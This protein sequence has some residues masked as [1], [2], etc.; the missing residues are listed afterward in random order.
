MSSKKIVSPRWKCQNYVTLKQELRRKNS[1]SVS[2]RQITD[3][4]AKE[5]EE[6]LEELVKNN[7][8]EEARI[9]EQ[10]CQSALAAESL[11][12]V[13]AIDRAVFIMETIQKMM[14]REQKIPIVCLTDNKSLFEELQKTKDPEEKRFVCALAPIRVLEMIL[15]V[16]EIFVR[17]I[18]SKEMTADILTKKGVNPRVLRYHLDSDE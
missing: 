13:K 9:S 3:P 5:K 16:N 8:F 14:K 17:R 10:V 12:M 18:A 4:F 2:S 15:S 1:V 6:E 7:V 11:D